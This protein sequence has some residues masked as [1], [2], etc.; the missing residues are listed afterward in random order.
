MRMVLRAAARRTLPQRHNG[1]SA[2][3]RATE[4]ERERELRI[5]GAREPVPVKAVRETGNRK[6]LALRERDSS[7]MAYAGQGRAIRSSSI[8]SERE[9]E[10]PRDLRRV[11]PS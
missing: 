6:L 9:E 11:R 4:D 10:E 8:E 1:R 7:A 3:P 5:A 2:K